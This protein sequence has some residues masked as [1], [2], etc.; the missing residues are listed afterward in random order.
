MSTNKR[1]LDDETAM[2]SSDKKIFKAEELLDGAKR[3]VSD[4]RQRMRDEGLHAYIVPSQDAHMS[5]YVADCYKRR[6]YISG[7]TGSAGTVLVTLEEALCWTDGRYF[8]QAEQELAPFWTL[9]KQGK[10]CPTVEKWLVD[11]LGQKTDAK[12]ARKVGVDPLVLTQSAAA[13]YTALF[14]PRR[15]ELVAVAVNLVDA[16]WG[17]ARPLPPL[18]KA[19]MLPLERTGKSAA[20]KLTALRA[21]M[22]ANNSELI[23][24]SALDEIAYMLNIRGSDVTFNPVVISYLTVALEGDAGC[25]LRWYVDAAK[26]DAAL[27]RTISDGLDSGSTSFSVQP[28]DNLVSDLTKFAE[29]KNGPMVWLPSSAGCQS[30][31]S[32][33]AMH[34]CIPAKQ[35]IDEPSPVPLMK[36]IKTEAEKAGMRACHLRDAV[37]VTQYL[38]WLE[39]T[40]AAG[41]VVTEFTGAAKLESFRRKLEGFVSLSFDT[42]SSIGANGAVIHYKPKE[43]DCLP[44]NDREVYLC[45]SGGQYL[46]GTTDITRTVHFGT[47]TAHEQRCW[48]RVLQSH[49]AVDTAVFPANTTTG[50]NL[51]VLAR[52]PLWR[53]G[54]D[55]NHGTGHG[56]GAFLNVHEGP[57]GLSL[58]IGAN[59]V[60][61]QEGMTITNEP[62]YYEAATSN[63][64]GFGVR[65]E[66]V[67]LMVKKDTEHPPFQGRTFLGFETLTFVP[68]QK[69]LLDLSLLR[70]HEMDW[71]NNYHQQCFEKVAPLLKSMTAPEEVD[72]VM[73]RFT[74]WTSPV[75]TS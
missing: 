28:Y 40:L 48:T 21:K 19:F 15:I 32:S 56:V 13:D 71:L 75:P 11:N 23:A 20:E 35:V 60:G 16:V 43:H 33:W 72:R 70:P 50:Y 58:R 74:G 57:H 67:L 55:F 12:D 2:Q 36:A 1:K 44:L 64:G 54:L 52:E 39:D 7:F 47:P 61:F 68:F 8:V 69:S 46:D 18:G 42:I 65:H 66:N 17:D 29:K 14:A 3:K 9:M 4:L 38:M 45:D 30:A 5:E 25:D 63:T 59:K 73:K 22:V 41:E 24:L 51:D 37:A 26:V 53:G 31:G 62:G 34:N 27:V 6:E 10:D 49:I